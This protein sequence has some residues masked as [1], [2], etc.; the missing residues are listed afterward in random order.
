ARLVGERE[1]LH[2]VER[3]RTR[4]RIV[5]DVAG[6]GLRAQPLADVALVGVRLLRERLGRQAAGAGEGLVEAELVADAHERRTDR[7][8]EVTDELAEKFVYAG[9]RHASGP[10]GLAWCRMASAHAIP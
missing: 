4:A 7:R 6:G 5:I 8:A 2:L 1:R 9:C 10:P 3:E